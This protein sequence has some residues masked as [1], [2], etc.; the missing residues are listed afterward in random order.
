MTVF[1]LKS[2]W[3]QKSVL[4]ELFTDLLAKILM[5]LSLFYQFL[6]FY[7]RIFP[8]TTLILLC[9][10]AIIM[11]DYNEYLELIDEPTLICKNSLELNTHHFINAMSAILQ[12]LMLMQ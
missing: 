7:F 5:N 9:Y 1:F 2:Q 8:I 4:F 12:K 3:D 10:S 11:Q 6:S